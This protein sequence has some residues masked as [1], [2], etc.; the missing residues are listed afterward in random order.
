M[1]IRGGLVCA[2]HDLSEGGLAV[3]AAE[4]SLAGLL[5]MDIDLG[6]V[7]YKGIVEAGEIDT[8]LLFSE[9]ASRFLVEVSPERRDAFEALWSSWHPQG[10]PV[11][12]VAVACIG[13]VTAPT[14]NRGAT[15]IVR[16]GEQILID[17]PVTQLQ[18]AWKGEEEA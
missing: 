13:T 4:M 15:F 17:I 11:Q 9:S 7:L 3:A 14:I 8:I 12:D 1:A 2:C 5:G 10:A 16:K 6:R 18:E